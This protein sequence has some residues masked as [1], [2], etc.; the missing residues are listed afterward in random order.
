MPAA[1][2][3]SSTARF[4]HADGRT[5]PLV[6]S[7]RV[8]GYP[9]VVFPVWGGLRIE[10]HVHEAG[11]KS[12]SRRLELAKIIFSKPVSGQPSGRRRLAR[13]GGPIAD[14]SGTIPLAT[15]IQFRA[16]GCFPA[17]VYSRRATGNGNFR[18][19]QHTA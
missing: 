13:I 6:D 1:V 17:S 8:M 7:L 3:H 16:A 19:L 18:A 4:V 11:H 15:E 12:A 9:E 10:L 2:V 14:N 5:A